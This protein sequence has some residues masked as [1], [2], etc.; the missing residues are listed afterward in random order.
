MWLVKDS[1]LAQVY[2]GERA[3]VKV[4]AL[5]DHLRFSLSLMPAVPPRT[6]T[7]LENLC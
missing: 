5:F 1:D 2:E 7:T 3:M 6:T 4:L